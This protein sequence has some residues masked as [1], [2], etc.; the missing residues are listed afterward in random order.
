M[1]IDLGN[2]SH[3]NFKIVSYNYMRFEAESPLFEDTALTGTNP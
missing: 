1:M 2:E 3:I